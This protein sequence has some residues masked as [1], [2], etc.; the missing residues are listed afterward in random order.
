MAAFGAFTSVAYDTPQQFKNMFGHLAYVLKGVA[1]VANLKSYHL[2]LEHD[3]GVLE[4][5][6]LFGMVSNTTSVGRFRNFPPGN[7]D[8]SDGLLEVTLIAPVRD[9]KDAEEFSR[10]LL[11]TDPSMLRSMLTSFSASSLVR[12]VA[13][14]A[15]LAANT[16]LTASSISASVR[17]RI[18]LI[19]SAC[20][21]SPVTSNRIEQVSV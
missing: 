18:F 4:G 21:S 9:V 5:D 2:R 3:G 16:V 17:W 6:Y 8:L 1:E 20:C 13:T 14:T 7:P 19:S 10:A 11:A 12:P 15:G